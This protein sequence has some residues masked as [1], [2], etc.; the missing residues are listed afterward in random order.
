[1]KEKVS[2]IELISQYCNDAKVRGMTSE[3]IIRYKS[4]LLDFNRFLTNRK[5]PILEVGNNILIIYLEYLQ[6]KNLAIKTIENYFTSISSF[7]TFLEFKELVPKNPVLAIRAR[8]LRRYKKDDEDSSERKLISLEEM[9]LLINSILNSRDKAIVTLFAKT[10]IRRDELIKIDIDDINWSEQSIRLKPKKKRSNRT[11][12]FDDE[13]ARILKRWIRNREGMADGI[14]AIFIGEG[15]ARLKRS[16]V[17]NMVVK[18]AEAV[19]LSDPDSDLLEDHFTPHCCR[20]WFTTYLRKNGMKREFIQM[21]RGDRRK[22]AVD[23][24]DHI[25]AQELR[26]SYLACIPQLGI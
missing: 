1:M 8:Y 10:G 7:F 9:K 18:Y 2:N 5:V 19:G 12:F 13:T 11:V 17:Y 4:S 25:D 16:G 3:S 22:E 23:I 6:R 15:G 14:S 21:L 24:Y 26:E 20:H